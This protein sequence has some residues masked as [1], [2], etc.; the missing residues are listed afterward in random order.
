MHAI[1]QDVRSTG[2][3][4]LNH[5]CNPAR[6]EINWK[7]GIEPSMQSRQTKPPPATSC[8]RQHTLTT[9]DDSTVF[10]VLLPPHQTYNE[11]TSTGYIPQY[12]P[13]FVFDSRHRLTYLLNWC[14]KPSQPQ[15]LYQ[16]RETFI[17]RYAVDRT[18]TAEIRREEQSEKSVSCRENL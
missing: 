8:W 13:T 14:F 5:A 11:D 15:I 12:R 9:L 2:N 3:V 17:K 1:L 16:C 10:K 6:R 7:C 4:E 18:N